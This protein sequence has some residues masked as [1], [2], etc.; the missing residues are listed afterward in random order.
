MKNIALGRYI[1]YD[2]FVHRLDPRTKILAMIALMISIFFKFP[3]VGMNFIVY[4]VI[5]VFIYILMRMTHI[6]LKTLFKSLKAMW[7]MIL[8]LLIINL[9]MPG[10]GDY[11]KIFSLKIYYSGI[12][13]TLYIVLRLVMMLS[14]T[15]ILTTS[16][17]PMDL[18]YAIEWLLTPFKVVRL[19]VHEIAMTISL[20]L[21][22]IPTLLEETDRI[23][24]AQ[25]SRG[26]DFQEGKLKE[27]LRAIV[28]LIV[29]LFLS[30]FQRS[31]E[32]ASAMEAR[33]Y[34]PSKKRTRYRIMK[35]KS[36][37]LISSIF[38]VV[39]VGLIMTAMIMKFDIIA[40]F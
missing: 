1:P 12:Y 25:A 8:F 2:T 4:G 18:T 17:K 5:L 31:D 13:N 26:V 16:T 20:A 9:I 3:S 21:R 39:F 37:D 40:L 30:A 28:S 36:R 27:K 15:M 11:F 24:K 29:P 33:G 22:F 19:P 10:T 14:L 35:F 34:D 38:I 23:M 32:L 6:K 7:F